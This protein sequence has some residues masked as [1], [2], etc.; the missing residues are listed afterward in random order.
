[1]SERRAFSISVLNVLCL[2]L[3]SLET[4]MSSRVAC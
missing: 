4:A 2:H 1:M 3:A